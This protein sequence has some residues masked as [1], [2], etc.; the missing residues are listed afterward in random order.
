MFVRFFT[1]RPILSI[2]VAGSVLFAAALIAEGQEPGILGDPSLYHA[3][4]LLLANDYQGAEKALRAIVLERPTS[5][6]ALNLLG[7]VLY[8]ENQPKD[9]LD[10][11]MRGAGIRP[12][13]ADVLK[14]MGLDCVLLKDTV[15][16]DRYLT[17]S[18][19]QDSTDPVVL[20]YL[21]RAKYT[22][23]HFPDAVD[24]FER[25]LH[26]EPQNVRAENNLGL[27][28][29]A[30]N[31]ADEAEAAYRRSIAMEKGA[32][33]PSEQPFLNI[34]ILLTN[35]GE[36]QEAITLL[37]R[38]A[39]L[40]PNSPKAHFALGRAYMLA[41]RWDDARKEMEEAVGLDATDG[42]LHFQLGKVY[43]HLGLLSQ[44]RSEFALSGRLLGSRAASDEP[45]P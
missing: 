27:A 5:V 7:Y 2:A 41:S 39:T 14:V 13:R 16:A 45:M 17:L 35:R 23:G 32:E 31:R 37:A 9:S 8:H 44:A 38:A 29:E 43:R 28:L 36:T 33:H 4:A 6:A 18:L 34:G 11:L 1:A 15:S 22:E 30:L 10:F 21:G 20:Y 25:V 12:P 3:K 40:A 42:G 24:A 19:Q 26:L